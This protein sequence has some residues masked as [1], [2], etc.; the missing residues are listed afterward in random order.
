VRVRKLLVPWVYPM[1]F[2]EIVSGIDPCRAFDYT[3]EGTT[4]REERMVLIN[5]ALAH[6]ESCKA[7]QVETIVCDECG[8]ELS[9][10]GECVMPSCQLD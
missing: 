3:G 4:S 6:E 10:W 8:V 1:T 7:C 2:D 9:W 5:A